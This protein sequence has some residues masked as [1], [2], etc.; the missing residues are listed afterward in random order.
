MMKII[1]KV[2]KFFIEKGLSKLFISLGE[3][4]VFYADK[5]EMCKLTCK[6]IQVENTKGAGDAFT[7][8]LIMASLL[9]YDTRQM[10]QYSMDLSE[11]YLC[12]KLGN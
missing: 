11:K 12:G 8:G 3:E 10:A 1:K 4:G 5:N 6:P 2:A 9:N 7:T